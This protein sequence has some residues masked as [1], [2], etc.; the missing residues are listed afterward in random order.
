MTPF[1]ICIMTNLKMRSEYN[2]IYVEVISK[3][4]EFQ[5][6]LILNAL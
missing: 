5:K 6:N 2:D 4:E 3:M 1:G